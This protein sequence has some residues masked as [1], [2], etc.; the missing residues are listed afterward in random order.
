MGFESLIFNVFEFIR[1]LVEESH[2]FGAMVKAYLTDLV[3]YLMAYSQITEEQ[4]GP[5]A[6][7]HRARG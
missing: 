2:Y 6:C 3:Y 5:L 4:V 1:A 7:L